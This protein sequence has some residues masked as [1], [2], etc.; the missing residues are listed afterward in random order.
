LEK[1]KI[2]LSLNNIEACNH[3]E[4]FA[5]TDRFP[6][7]VGLIAG[8]PYNTTVSYTSLLLLALH[9]NYQGLLNNFSNLFI[10]HP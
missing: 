2:E 5:T 4:Y 3:T 9:V 8:T 1:L 10:F 6:D 7:A